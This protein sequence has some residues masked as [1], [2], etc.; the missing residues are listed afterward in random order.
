MRFSVV[1]TTL[2]RREGVLRAAASILDQT[3]APCEVLV[4]DNGSQDGTPAAL[5][6]RFGAAVRVLIEPRR[7]LSA[8][9]NRAVTEAQGDVLAFLDDDARADPGWLA[10]LSRCFDETGAIGCGGPAAAEWEASPPKRILRSSKAQSYMGVF[11]L[12]AERRPLSGFRDF[13][14]GTN[15]A[16]R[17]G[18]FDAGERFL[19]I[20]WGRPV[21]GGDLE[22]SRRA[23]T[24]GAVWHEPAAIVHHRVPERKWSWPGLAATAYDYGM[25]KVAI[26][27]PL[28]PRGWEDLF[29]VDGY[30]SAFS[31]LG[32][33]AGLVRAAIFGRPGLAPASIEFQ[34][35]E[36][37][38][39]S[40]RAHA[41]GARERLQEAENVRPL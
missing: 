22:F 32:Y 31:A 36:N 41:H 13:L 20:S 18:L 9:R 34:G 23:M 17:R 30:I 10:A 37:G 15:C 12:G 2:D 35:E 8:A 16:Y 14:I 4:V 3:L 11:S 28:S 29:G 5:A 33:A 26:R 40:R 6:E 38:I 39:G 1:V 21:G 27:R 19:D 7:G 24:R 25:K